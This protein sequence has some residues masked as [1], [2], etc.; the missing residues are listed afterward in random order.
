[1][2]WLIMFVDDRITRI[3]IIA[4]TS[5]ISLSMI[6]KTMVMELADAPD[7]DAIQIHDS[8]DEN[9]KNKHIECFYC[10]EPYS[11]VVSIIPLLLLRTCLS[12]R[13]TLSNYLAIKFLRRRA[14]RKVNAACYNKRYRHCIQLRRGNTHGRVNKRLILSA[15]AV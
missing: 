13:R 6:I 15:A 5:S 4:Y 11:S 1:M 7:Q 14:R 9:P 3:R 12:T 2:L 8:N 10:C